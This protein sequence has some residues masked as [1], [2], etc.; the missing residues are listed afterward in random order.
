MQFIYCF[1]F[2]FYNYLN[3]SHLALPKEDTFNNLHANFISNRVLFRGCWFPQ[4]NHY[5]LFL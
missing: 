1:E 5:C 2:I 4:S 3:V